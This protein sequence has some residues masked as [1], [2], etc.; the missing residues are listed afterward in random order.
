MGELLEPKKMTVEAFMG[1]RAPRKMIPKFQRPFA[2]GEEEAGE[3]LGDIDR[4]MGR[5]EP[6][7]FI[8]ALLCINRPEGNDEAHEIVDGQQRLITMSLVFAAAQHLIKD[9]DPTLVR[10][11]MGISA[12]KFS[13]KM[14]EFLYRGGELLEDEDSL[15]QRPYLV[16]PSEND[17]MAFRQIVKNGPGSSVKK[18]R[19]LVAVYETAKKFLEG[20][21]QGASG[22][23]YVKD[24][25]QFLVSKVMLVGIFISDEANAYEI[26][27]VLNDRGMDLA[28]TDLIKNK[29]LSCFGS[30]DERVT[31]A[32]RHW[33]RALKAG[34]RDR[35][36]KMRDYVRC[37]LQ[38]HKGE[39]IDPKR[40]YIAV[41]DRLKTS[42]PDKVAWEFLHN[43]DNHCHKFNAMMCA[44][45]RLWEE[46]F[47]AKTGAGKI[48]PV[49][50]Y[51]NDYRVTYTI[52]FSM[53]YTEQP[54]EF[55]H[56]AFRILQTFIKRSRAARERFSVMEYYEE[57][58]AKLAN[59]FYKKQGP[60]T[61]KSFFKEIKD[62][63]S[64]EDG[65]FVVPDDSFI[66]EVV[67][68]QRMKDTEAKAMLLEL[69]DH[70]QRK[71]KT[72]VLVDAD[73]ITLEHV[74]PKKPKSK[75]WPEF[76]DEETARMYGSRLGNLT[77]LE[78]RRNTA[79]SNNAFAEKQK[80]AYAPE[81]CGI[82]L[83]NELCEYSEWTPETIRG[84]QQRLAELAAEVWSFA[85]WQK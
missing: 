78:G 14:S 26:F 13:D 47:D 9:A 70:I 74:F 22:Y 37:H 64:D 56:Q 31:N 29:L 19:E 7:Y 85:E 77:L 58:F 59:L 75:E 18:H 35:S 2:W 34:C 60:K 54:A 48:G 80:L 17:K 79:A 81:K 20:K 3:L 39:K 84:R 42:S 33:Q 32:Y 8:G 71:E 21:S 76:E 68:R 36:G 12:D 82:L 11:Q 45:E 65:L 5:G 49:V 67:K 23:R 83:T 62:I 53:L 24:F 30:D 43:L 40:L 61:A 51:L 25:I 15:S 4:A 66:G 57:R 52:M 55:V 73:D 27:E 38:M 16:E 50:G 69:S 28:V 41:N 1:A 72:G 63:D 6:L 10:K 46:D 44:T